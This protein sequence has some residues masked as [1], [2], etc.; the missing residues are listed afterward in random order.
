METSSDNEKVDVLCVFVHGFKGDDSAFGGFPERLQHIVDQ[1]GDVRVECIVFPAY[2]TRGELSAATERFVEWLTTTVVHKEGG[3]GKG[4]GKTKVVLCGHSMGGLLIADALIAIAKSSAPITSPSA[5][6]SSQ[7][8]A[9][10]PRIIACIAFDTPYYGINPGVFKNTATKAVQYVQ[11]AHKLA[12]GL[13]ILGALGTAFRGESKNT[14]TNDQ[15][16]M[17]SKSLDENASEL[18]SQS[19]GASSDPNGSPRRRKS[20]T[21]TLLYSLGG[22]VLA[23]AAAGTAIYQRKAIATG[24]SQAQA[25]VDWAWAGDH[26][27]YVRNLWDDAA[28]KARVDTLVALRSERSVHFQNFYTSLPPTSAFSNERT[29]ILLPSPTWP[30]FQ[31]FTPNSNSL[32]SSE[33][34]AHTNMFHGSS[35]D[36]FYDLGLR[37]AEILRRAIEESKDKDEDTQLKHTKQKGS[38]SNCA[39][40]A[41]GP[42]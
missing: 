14:Q 20:S 41:D 34:D 19:A 4:A 18:V 21:P 16:T 1:H 12:T 32:S 6:N 29:F 24:I 22:A 36:G 8:A 35:N 26:L 5:D 39:D 11:T 27:K 17:G 3:N 15:P 31:F 10:W 30:S 33:I 40:A 9:L 7:P 42:A 37:T 23:G 28:L 2:E 25:N 38:N 13:G